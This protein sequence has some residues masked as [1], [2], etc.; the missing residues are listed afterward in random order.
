[1]LLLRIATGL[2]IYVNTT[3]LMS[4]F[5]VRV[6]DFDSPPIGTDAGL[7]FTI[8]ATSFASPL[9]ES[10]GSIQLE[11]SNAEDTGILVQDDGRAFA[12][13]KPIGGN[14]WNINTAVHGNG[15]L[16]SIEPANGAPW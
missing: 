15:V 2:V 12:L 5:R 10:A 9:Q 6:S 14:Q 3:P 7:L 8:P 16:E 11:G 4:P 13:H 1:M